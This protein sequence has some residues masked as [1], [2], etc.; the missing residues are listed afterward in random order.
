[1][2]QFLGMSKFTY[3]VCL[4]LFTTREERAFF[5]WLAEPVV[6]EAGP[7]LIHQDKANCIEFTDNLLGR[8]V[9][10]VVA[11]YDAVETILIA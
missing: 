5:S 6:T 4:F 8:V 2:G 3:S 9:D 1:M 7:K 10:Q 11:W